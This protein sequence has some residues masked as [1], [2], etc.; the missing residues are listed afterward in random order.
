[1]A[2]S[3]R[4]QPGTKTGTGRGRTAGGTLTSRTATRTHVDE[5]IQATVQVLPDGSKLISSPPTVQELPG[6][7]RIITAPQ[8]EGSEETGLDLPLAEPVIFTNPTQPNT[9]MAGRKWKFG[10]GQWIEIP[11][12]Y[13]RFVNGHCVARTQRDV[14]R[15]RARY[16]VAGSGVKNPQVWEEPASLLSTEAAA[17]RDLQLWT[18]RNSKDQILFWTY[19]PDAYM[20]FQKTYL[21]Q[22]GD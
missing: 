13:L 19:H 14:D 6:G 20:A 22:R 7:V 4:T 12:K 8:A 5:E 18:F 9:T 2:R 17:A 10:P 21:A 11:R 16:R 15:L 1:M 3:T